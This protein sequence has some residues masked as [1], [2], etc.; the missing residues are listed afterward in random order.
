MARAKMRKSTQMGYFF[1][2][3]HGYTLLVHF[4]CSTQ[5][6]DSGPFPSKFLCPGVS[7]GVVYRDPFPA[8]LCQKAA[9]RRI[10]ADDFLHLFRADTLNLNPVRVHFP[11]TDYHPN[12]PVLSLKDHAHGFVSRLP[13]HPC[14]CHCSALPWSAVFGTVPGLYRSRSQ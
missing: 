11:S 2:V 3:P 10:P 6:P 5:P 8:L 13:V 7:G 1:I 4:K 12:H 9:I 14:P